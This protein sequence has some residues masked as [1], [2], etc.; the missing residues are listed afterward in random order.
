MGDAAAEGTGKGEL[1]TFEMV[2]DESRDESFNREDR[3]GDA[4]EAN[5]SRRGNDGH[6]LGGFSL[7]STHLDC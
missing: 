3:E 5:T 6:R 1:G 4:L 2:S 7:G